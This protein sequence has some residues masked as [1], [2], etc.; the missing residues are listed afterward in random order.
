MVFD[1][2]ILVNQSNLHYIPFSGVV[3]HAGYCVGDYSA[4]S[5]SQSCRP[6]QPNAKTTDM[7]LYQTAGN[8][9]HRA[10]TLFAMLPWAFSDF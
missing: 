9:Y 6:G 1:N 5:G 2:T 10:A 7:L 8:S 4:A 3:A